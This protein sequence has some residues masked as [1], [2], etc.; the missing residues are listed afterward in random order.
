MEEHKPIEPSKP[1]IEFEATRG[2][3]PTDLAMKLWQ[4]HAEQ[5]KKGSRVEFIW[6]Q[7]RLQVRYVLGGFNIEILSTGA[8]TLEHANYIAGCVKGAMTILAE[9]PGFVQVPAP[10]TTKKDGSLKE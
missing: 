2:D 10:E 9:S 3:R 8:M 5:L 7:A 6:N 4:T 1:I